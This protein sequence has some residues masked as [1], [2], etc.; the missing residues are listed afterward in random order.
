[1]TS[2]QLSVNYCEEVFLFGMEQ[3]LAARYKTFE[4]ETTERVVRM[5]DEGDP[6]GLLPWFMTL[7]RFPDMPWL[8][9]KCETSSGVVLGEVQAQPSMNIT[10]LEQGLCDY[11]QQQYRNQL[12]VLVFTENSG[13]FDD[14]DHLKT[15]FETRVR[16]WR[17]EV[18]TVAILRSGDHMIW[19]SQDLQV[20]LDILVCNPALL[21]VGADLRAFPRII[22]KRPPVTLARLRQ[23]ACC[24]LRPGQTN[25]VEVMFC[26]YTNSMAHHWFSLMQHAKQQRPT[27]DA[28]AAL[29]REIL[30]SHQE[31]V[32]I[33][34]H[35]PS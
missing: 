12:P 26:M 33:W 16:G 15:L 19:L 13:Q 9:W 35:E 10:P 8:N 1:M 17:A 25:D 18:P 20:G 32:P 34:S 14:Q 24:S 30:K 22:Y 2:Q 6:S 4:R 7:L 3:D 21:E 31:G 28:L 5:L 27:N 29:A 11:V 23:S